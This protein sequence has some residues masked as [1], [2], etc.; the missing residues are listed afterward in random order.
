MKFLC[1]QCPTLPCLK[2]KYHRRWR[3][4]LPSSE[5]DRV[6]PLRN[7]RRHIGYI[8]IKVF[9]K[10]LNSNV[11]IDIRSWLSKKSGVAG[12]QAI[13][14]AKRLGAKYTKFSEN[15]ILKIAAEELSKEKTIGWFQG[16]MEFG[17][18]FGGSI[19]YCRSKIE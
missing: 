4:W 16:R 10:H 2:T 9:C 13:A 19:N 1:R 12:L 8:F 6:W 7:N 14:T 15:D 3:A 18:S 17:S 5:W 11:L